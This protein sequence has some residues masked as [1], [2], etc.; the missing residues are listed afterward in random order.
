M[1]IKASCASIGYDY[2]NNVQR[3]QQ[4]LVYEVPKR[5]GRKRM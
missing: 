4:Y 1:R 2:I 3:L 5:W